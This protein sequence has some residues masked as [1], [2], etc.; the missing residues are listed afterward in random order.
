MIM[1]VLYIGGGFVGACSAAV[2]ADS[3]HNTLVY[4][5]DEKKVENLGSCD[6]DKIEA[7][8]FENGLAEMLIR[9]KENIKFSSDYNNVI[10]FLDCVEVVF[11]CLPTP[12]KNY[13]SGESDLSYYY[14]A[15][16]K[17]AANLS[18]RNGGKQEKYVVI[19]NKSTVPIDMVDETRRIM[20]NFKVVNFGAVSN[21]E[22]L[23]EGKAIEGSIHPDRVLVGA[24]SQ[25]DFD[26]IRRL[27]QRFSNSS[28]IKYIEVNPKEAAAAK[29]AANYILFNKVVA[30]YE[31]VGRMCEI[32]NGIKFENIR[33]ALTSEPR[34]GSWGFYNSVYAGGS[35]FI[36]DAL[37]L[38]HQMEEAGAN[39]NYV[40]QT[41]NSNTFQRD[42]FFSRA[43]KEAN[44][45]WKD[46]N[47]A[48]LGVAFKQDTNDI[49]N[50]AAID[51]VEHL[52]NCGVETVRIYDPAAMLMF[53]NML[54]PIKNVH[55]EK[56]VYFDNEIDALRGTNA[57]LILTD[58]PKFRAV[59]DV[60]MENCKTPYL[61]MDGRRMIA[62]QFEKL[63]DLGYDIL[64]VGSPFIKGKK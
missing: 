35:C 41:L 11:M 37:S 39:A 48:I 10:E 58:W 52:I 36:K 47:V 55:Y 8:L 18:K 33:A 62:D 2:S 16:E 23:V 3:G 34:I 42:H 12:E 63:S 6:R 53:K 46:K 43:Q 4:D 29:L 61:I 15:T 19:I 24:S 26:I 60:I 21:P 45:D 64:A 25:K 5:I 27:Y 17:L 38:A 28:S 32:F 54:D 44:F 20:E 7:C 14:A 56:I 51:I 22:F 9:N 30:T 40:R 49:R 59:G 57:V 13:E 50:S 1:N 31:V